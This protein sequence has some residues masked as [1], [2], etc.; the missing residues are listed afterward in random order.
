MS[1]GSSQT[2]WSYDAIGNVQEEKRTTNSITKSFVYTYNR[3]SSIATIQYP[4]GRKITYQ[5]GDAQRP[6]SAVDS[7]NSINY[8]T[9]AHYAPQGAL[10]AAIYGGNQFIT[11]I[12]N[13]RLQ[14][15]WLYANTTAGL[16]WSGTSC[17]ASA[18]AGS[19]LDL[20]YS[21]NLG[22]NDNGNVIGITN[23]RDT[24]RSQAFSYDYLNRLITAQSTSTHVTNPN[25]CWTEVYGYDVV[26]NLLSIQPATDPNYNLCAT[27]N[28]GIAVNTHNQMSNPSGFVYDAAGNFTGQ[29]GST[30]YNYN[31]E[32]QMTNASTSLGAAGYAYDGDGKRVE[33]IT[34]TTPYKIYWYG[35]NSDP[36]AESDGSGNLTDEFI[37]FGG[38]RIARRLGP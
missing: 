37:F 25:E 24:A 16:A 28:L 33:K 18:G 36:L 11:L 8:V 38:R 19:I 29:T 23:N 31:A 21:F 34:G 35:I 27:E 13:S 9:S 22:A 2:S 5:P 7:T 12:Y 14:P 1:D 20:K 6:L 30:S 15:C 10:A 17:T 4:S 26:G 3:D 32:S